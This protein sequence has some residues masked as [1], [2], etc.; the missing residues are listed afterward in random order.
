MTLGLAW[1]EAGKLK[2]A[3]GE[4]CEAVRLRPNDPFT[5]YYLG[6]TFEKQGEP[7][8]AAVHYGLAVEH[9]P[10]HV[11][12]LLALASIRA[13]SRDAALR[14][15]E[16]AVRL[17]ARACDLTH[18]ED[19]TALVTL[20]EAYAE[21]GRF[22]DAASA[23]RLALEIARAAGNENLAATARQRIDLYSQREP[24]RGQVL[25]P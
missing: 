9:K 20:S 14:D 22:A 25:A 6:T 2:E 4:F 19:P 11:A 5:H 12:A 7:D 18:S 15:G 23:A 17:A 16:E 13:T 10:D 24:A 1:L 8:Q 21:A 3:N